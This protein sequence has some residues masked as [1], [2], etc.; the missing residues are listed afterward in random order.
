LARALY[1]YYRIDAARL[2][3][4]ASTV[5]AF[6]ALLRHAHPPLQAALLRRPGEHEGQVTLM[7]TYAMP[8]GIDDALQSKIDSAATALAPWQRGARHTE[9]FEPLA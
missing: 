5:H 3:E 8:G 2:A 4:A 6:Q 1:I 9:V 7:E